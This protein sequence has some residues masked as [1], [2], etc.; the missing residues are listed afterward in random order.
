LHG[1]LK[2]CLAFSLFSVYAILTFVQ[3]KQA[4]LQVQKTY[5]LFI[6]GGFVRGEIGRV[7]PAC[8]K[9]GAGAQLQ[10]GGELNVKRYARRDLSGKMWRGAHAEN[11][12]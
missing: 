2:R 9:G 8:G 7:L 6:G 11:P 1:D 10:R 12:Y 3:R 4:W 5:K